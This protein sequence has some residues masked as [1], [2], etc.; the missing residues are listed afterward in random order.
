MLLQSW[1]DRIRIFPA[2]P[3]DWEDAVFHDLRAEGAFLVSAVRRKGR[4]QLVR[5]KSLAG[6]PC[7]IQAELPEDVRIQVPYGRQIPVKRLDHGVWELGLRP[8]EEAVLIA[9]EAAE[10]QLFVEPAAAERHLCN[11]FGGRKPW[12]LFGFP[13]NDDSAGRFQAR[14]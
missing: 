5:V 4:T 1:G 9:K 11:Y 14:L 3:D 2:V 8:G 13:V 10:E 12:R 7:R 6:E